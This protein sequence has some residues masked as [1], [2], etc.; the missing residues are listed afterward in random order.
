[1]TL[2]IS[3]ALE[4]LRDRSLGGRRERLDLRGLIES[5]ADDYAMWART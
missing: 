4:F 1:M 2:M 5:V 3:A